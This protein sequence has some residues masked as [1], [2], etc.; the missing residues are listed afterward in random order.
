MS[1]NGGLHL[2]AGENLEPGSFFSGLID[3]VR[4]YN[5]ALG[6]EEIATLAQ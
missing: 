6:P 5:M 3:E 4:N 2:G 1:S